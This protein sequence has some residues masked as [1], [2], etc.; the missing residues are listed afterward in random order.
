MR[1]WP[2]ALLAAACASGLPPPEFEP[3]S[4]SSLPPPGAYPG[5]AAVVLLDRGEVRF[6]VDPNRDAPV[7]RLRRLRRVQVL[8]AGAAETAVTVPI[9]PGTGIEGF[10]VRVTSPDRSTRIFGDAAPSTTRGGL[11]GRTIDTGPLLFGA[12]VESVHDV[13]F[14]DPRFLPPWR[15]DDSL[16][17]VRSQF[18]VVVPTGFSVD[19]RFSREG[20]FEP[21][22]P[23]RFETDE[24]VRFSWSLSNL[25]ARAAEAEMPD[26]DLLAPRAHVLFLRGPGGALGFPTWDDVGVWLLAKVPNWSSLSDA[27]VA[28]ALRVAGELGDEERALRLAEVVA[29][30]L[31]PGP[32]PAPPAWRAPLMHPDQ[33]LAEQRAD[34]TNRGLLLVALLRGIGLPAV[35]ALYAR[36]DGD[37]LLPDAPTVRSV[38]GVA[39]VLLRPEGMLVLDPSEPTV[40]GRVSAPNLQG[41][42]LVLLREDRA[43]VGIAPTSAA[44]DSRTELSY[45]LELDPRGDVFGQLEATLT[46]AEAGALR[47]RL[48]PVSPEQ[49]AE[50]VTAF[51]A[52][53]GATLG[54]TGVRI[55]DLGGLRR[56][57]VLGGPVDA[58]GLLPVTDQGVAA[59][60]S[61]L[62]GDFGPPPPEIRRSP[63]RLGVPR[64]TVLRMTI[65]V[66]EG[67]SVAHVPPVESLRG[68]G[69]EIA[70]G[71]RTETTR[72]IG[73]SLGYE[74]RAFEVPVAEHRRFRQHHLDLRALAERTLVVE[75]P[76]ETPLLY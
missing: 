71:G 32:E 11:P 13:W 57:L 68:P 59:P 66:P 15:F 37:R 48:L 17:T 35:P 75:R 28:E 56:P 45:T 7:A 12:V 38:H 53:R 27:T 76:A 22:P 41:Q 31:A 33:V 18:V 16:P 46:G 65:T 25:P 55:A 47:A 69:L 23:E 74:S 20:Q 67:W 34:P 72:R 44:E 5:A 10:R 19:L 2:F 36:R 3:F 42:R 50:Q 61:K 9:E 1:P 54:P 58:R 14:D 6:F 21:R 39:A 60:L 4:S 51:L 62:L 49:Y 43:E 63:R 52:E 64:S 24:G 29:R 26:V 30:D 40:S 8:D 73:I 70:L